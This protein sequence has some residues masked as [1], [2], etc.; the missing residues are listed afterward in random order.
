[1]FLMQ[2]G[3]MSHNLATI[4]SLDIGTRDSSNFRK[5][6]TPYKAIM[7]PP[8]KASNAAQKVHTT[9][10]G[11][12]EQRLQK[13]KVAFIKCWD[14]VMFQMNWLEKK[15]QNHRIFSKKASKYQCLNLL[16][17]SLLL[18]ALRI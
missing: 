9:T 18:K 12:Y 3:D 6:T 11:L 7:P 16:K 1:M 13:A 8:T 5:L 14:T 4:P 2:T 17:D 10:T 15:S